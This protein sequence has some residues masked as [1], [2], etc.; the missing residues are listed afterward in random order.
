MNDDIVGILAV[1]ITSIIVIGLVFYPPAL[2]LFVIFAG[3][4]SFITMCRTASRVSRDIRAWR[5]WR[6]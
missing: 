2:F 5:S 6:E 4:F 1:T 3:I